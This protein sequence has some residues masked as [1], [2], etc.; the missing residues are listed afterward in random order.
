M[1]LGH[2]LSKGNCQEMESL[3]C[4]AQ[5][6]EWV[7][8][9]LEAGDAFAGPDGATGLRSLLALQVHTLTP[10]NFY[11]VNCMRCCDVCIMLLLLPLQA[12]TG[13]DSSFSQVH[14]RQSCLFCLQAGNFFAAY[15]AEN[16]DALHSMLDKELWRRLPSSGAGV[17]IMFHLCAVLTLAPIPVL[18]SSFNAV[19]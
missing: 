11:T 19:A 14:S 12:C 17:P 10:L 18:F 7:Q 13:Q 16:L 6:S 3:K 4:V 8:R 9:I 15:H 2:L 1:L 5:V